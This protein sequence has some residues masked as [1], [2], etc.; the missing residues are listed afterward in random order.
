MVR[1]KNWY[2]L[3]YDTIVYSHLIEGTGASIHTDCDEIRRTGAE[4]FAHVT[5]QVNGRNVARRIEPPP[6][7]QQDTSDYLVDGEA[8]DLLLALYLRLIERELPAE[9]KLQDRG[10]AGREA[11]QGSQEDKGAWVT[12]VLKWVSDKKSV[13]NP[14]FNAIQVHAGICTF[15]EHLSTE[16]KEGG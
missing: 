15:V 11:A 6:E 3:V 10:G 13:R 1:N 16:L 14:T 9:F 8:Y 5:F 7:N 2:I 12:T 4:S